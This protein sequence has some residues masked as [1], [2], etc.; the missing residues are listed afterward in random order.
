MCQWATAID[1]VK[2][3]AHMHTHTHK[4]GYVA[5]ALFEQCYI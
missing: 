3:H 5:V 2:T 1:M 4:A